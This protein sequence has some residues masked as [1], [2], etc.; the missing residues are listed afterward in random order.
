M[1]FR[2]Y[3]VI[4]LPQVSGLLALAGLALSLVFHWYAPFASHRVGAAPFVA[5]VLLGPF[6]AGCILS[7]ALHAPLHRPFS[8]TLP[9]LRRNFLQWHIP[10]LI[11]LAV[12]LS[13]VAARYDRTLP[14]LVDACVAFAGLCLMLPFET[15]LRWYGSTKLFAGIACSVV[16]ASLWANETRDVLLYLPWLTIAASLTFAALCCRLCFIR[17][18]IRA[19]SRTNVISMAES[20]MLDEG[21]RIGRPEI[22]SPRLARSWTHGPIGNSTTNWI[23]AMRHETSGFR[24]R[25]ATTLVTLPL[26]YLVVFPSV[27]Y[28]QLRQ[29]EMIEHK[30]PLGQYI[31]R[32]LWEHEPFGPHSAL[33]QE[34]VLMHLFALLIIP[35]S[36]LR[37]QQL[38]PI[39]RARRARL[40]F[41]S[42]WLDASR[43]ILTVFGGIIALS[44]L[45]CWLA[46]WP[47][48]PTAVPDFVV[49]LISLAPLISFVH[50]LRFRAQLS[51]KR[52]PLD[53]TIYMLIYLLGGMIFMLMNTWRPWLLSPTGLITFGIAFVASLF[54]YRTTVFHA[55][56]RSDLI[57][58]SPAA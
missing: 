22:D 17:A 12:L 44:W 47:F 15:G 34:I 3:L 57:R 28:F 24:S 32:C 36:S 19:R 49:V 23:R 52:Y 41:L 18:R 13:H 53:G 56:C 40:T 6:F 11:I 5:L 26:T 8:I 9:N 45:N 51:A 50:W 16:L 43:Q 25:Y 39:S 29:P 35:G 38:Y 14:Q 31:H 4:L 33:L 30:M 54:A 27:A 48:R 37:P 55:Y 42:S 20:T 1:K 10:T 46:G 21:Q 58:R 2:T 7:H